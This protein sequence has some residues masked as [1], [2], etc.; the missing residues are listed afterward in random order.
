MGLTI[1]YLESMKHEVAASSGVVCLLMTC[2][3]ALLQLLA[4]PKAK[5]AESCWPGS[6]NALTLG[7]LQV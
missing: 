1:C 2:H 7:S 4:V 6:T 5:K 3:T